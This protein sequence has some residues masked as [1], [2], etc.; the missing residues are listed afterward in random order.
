MI[1]SFW[2]HEKPINI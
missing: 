2:W 1:E